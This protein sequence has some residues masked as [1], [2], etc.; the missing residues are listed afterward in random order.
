M[1]ELTLLKKNSSVYLQIFITI[2]IK[3]SHC[4]SAIFLV[5]F[6]STFHE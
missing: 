1:R 5:A 4:L 6:F 2:S 3:L